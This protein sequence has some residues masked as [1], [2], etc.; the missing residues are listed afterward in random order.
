MPSGPARR[1]PP[2][3]LYTAPGCGL[4]EHAHALLREARE[5][6]GFELA[7]VDISGDDELEARYRVEL[8]VVEIAGE[9]AFAFFVDADEL[10][11]RLLAR[12]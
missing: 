5:E 3:T 4:C 1:L 6:L 2:V 9:R 11:A 7:V 8:P 12:P 10:R